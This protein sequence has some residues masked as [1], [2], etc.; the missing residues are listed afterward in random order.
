M[1][2]RKVT[3]KEYTEL[4]TSVRLSSH[5]KICA[6][7]MKNLVKSMDELKKDVKEMRAD[8]NRWKGAGG[9]IILLGGIIGSVFY[10][11]VGK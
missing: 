11:L 2:K 6:E 9:I 4:M 7:R 5:E 8:M 3:P 1:P 10:Y